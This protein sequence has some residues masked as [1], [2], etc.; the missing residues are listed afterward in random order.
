MAEKIKLLCQPS[1]RV[2]GVGYFRSTS[3]HTKLQ[4]LF[5]ED[6]DVTIEFDVNDKP[7]DY[8]SQFDIIHFS[9]NITHS[10]ERGKEILQYLKDKP[11]ITV[12]DIDDYF[13]LGAFHPLSKTFAKSHT[14]ELLI[15]NLRNADYVTT[16][17][18]IFAERI[19]KINPNVLVFPNAIDP[20]EKQF[21]P[22]P[23]KS[24]RI[25]FGI[26]CGSSHRH[27]IELLRG[28]TKQI[29]DDLKQKIQ[30]VLCGFDLNGTVRY[31]DKEGKVRARPL[32]PQE[33]VWY[34]YETLLTEKY[35]LVSKQYAT[36]L[37]R[38][39]PNFDLLSAENEYYRRFWTKPINNY[40]THYN[41]IDILLAPLKECDFNKY[42]SQLKVVEAGF[43][44]KGIIATDFG[45]YTIDLKP[46]IVDG[47]VTD[48]GNA[49]LVEP[50]KNH[51]QW[52]KHIVTIA[53][54]P[55]Y[56]NILGERLYETVKD[57]YNL[58]NVTKERADWYKKIFQKN[59]EVKI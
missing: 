40:A 36:F 9:K 26:I 15:H 16:T 51:K 29:P 44:H 49:M 58:N 54:N 50:R 32:M 4:E 52:L 7:N 1:D 33:S 5:P 38:F 14:K 48:S 46:F 55:E 10:Y 39:M 59:L 23:T 28:V 35:T 43:F 17:T 57:R 11:T 13:D 41:Q 25:R 24:D 53:K 18:P 45:P 37:N 22:S 8:F 21:I 20:E 12:M 27:D 3:P 6:F 2:G 42:K 56:V 30:F 19:S 34:D 31:T 47:K